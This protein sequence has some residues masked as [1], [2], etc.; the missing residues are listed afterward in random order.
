MK[1]FVTVLLLLFLSSHSTA[2]DDMS[3]ETAMSWLSLIDN[4]DYLESWEQ[5]GAYFQQEVPSAQ[6]QEAVSEVRDPL[7][8]VISRQQVESKAYQSLPG[9]PEGEYLVLRF[10]TRFTHQA[11]VIETLTLQSVDGDWKVLGYFVR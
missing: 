7:G 9:V 1:I 10:S 11:E 4:G 3:R 8:S 2:D 6:W 5:A